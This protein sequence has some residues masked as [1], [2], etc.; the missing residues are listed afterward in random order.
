MNVKI[1]QTLYLSVGWFFTG[2]GFIGAFLPVL[3]TTP[4]LLVAVWAFS[5]SSPKLKRW[6]YTHPQFGPH[7]R[8]W[9]DH[10]AITTRAKIFAV[11]LMGVSVGFSTLLS[12][13]LYLPIALSLIMVAV[14]TFI[15]TRPAPSTVVIKSH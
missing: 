13:S 2:L 8:N 14:A 4:F 12:E 10:G 6:L 11:S 9:F 15:L 3:P 5:K 7:I 1:R